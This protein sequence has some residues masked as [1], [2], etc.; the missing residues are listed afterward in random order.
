MREA[1]QIA[2]T[3]GV[4]FGIGDTCRLQ[5]ELSCCSCCLHC[6]GSGCSGSGEAPPPDDPTFPVLGRA[7]G[8]P[9]SGHAAACGRL[10]AAA[11]LGGAGASHAAPAAGPVVAKLKT[12][13]AKRQRPIAGE[14]VFVCEGDTCSA[15]T[16]DQRDQLRSRLSRAGATRRPADELR[17]RRRA[18]RADGLAGC[19]LAAHK[20]AARGA[21]GRHVDWCGRRDSN[22]HSLSGNRF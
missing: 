4:S 19:N 11:L 15:A 21:G 2:R 9:R 12:P 10:P 6:G 13:V 20:S 8:P 22:P 5:I 3:L 1:W 16:P 18:P 14:A 7:R 17:P